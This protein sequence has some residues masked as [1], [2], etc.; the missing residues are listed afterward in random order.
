MLTGY[1]TVLAGGD[2]TIADDLVQLAFLAAFQSW[3]VLERRDAERR[4]AWLRNVCRNKWIDALRRRNKL[5]ALQPELDRIYARLEPDPA[6]TVVARDELE[7]CLKVMQGFP[8]RR[9]EIALLHFVDDHSPMRIA[10]ILGIEASGVR[11]HI[12]E[13]RR[14]LR[15]AAGRPAR[16]NTE[17]VR[18]GERA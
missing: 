10:E 14:A 13:A 17:A 2:E 9:S 7:R 1:A 16:A 4:R 15:E 3:A 8:A 5:G 11:K 12:T 18:E 6:D